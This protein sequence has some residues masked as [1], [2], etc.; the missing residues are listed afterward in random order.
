MIF[1]NFYRIANWDASTMESSVTEVDSIEEGSKLLQSEFQAKKK[2]L[3]G[4]FLEEK[5]ETRP[6]DKQRWATCRN[7]ESATIQDGSNCYKWE[8]VD[9]S[10]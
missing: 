3:G 5:D 9:M 4:K 6:A 7:G 8:L 1:V 10:W 2:E